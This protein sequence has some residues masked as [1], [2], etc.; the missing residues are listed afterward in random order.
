MGKC[1]S[2]QATVE[3]APAPAP[4]P[5]LTTVSP[6]LIQFDDDGDLVATILA[7]M[8]APPPKAQGEVT[9]AEPVVPEITEQQ[10]S[11]HPADMYTDAMVALEEYRLPVLA[12]FVAIVMSMAIAAMTAAA[13]L[14]FG[15]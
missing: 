6:R 9:E 10:G 11:P 1:Q 2:K 15:A 8:N 5:V 7:E 4:V 3:P 13:S 12:V 14:P